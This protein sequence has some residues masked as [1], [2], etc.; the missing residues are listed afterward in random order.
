MPVTLK[1]LIGAWRKTA[2]DEESMLPDEVEFFP[3]GTYRAKRHGRKRG[4]WDEASFDLQADA[5]IRVELANDSKV[6]YP[7]SIDDDELIIGSGNRRTRYRRAT[8]PKA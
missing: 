6:A 2:E 1:D 7:V 5:T 4:D 3:D 8:P